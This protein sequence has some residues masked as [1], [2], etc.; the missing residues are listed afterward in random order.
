M[1]EWISTELRHPVH[2]ESVLAHWL[3]A[4][5]N[6]PMTVVAKY[7]FRKARLELNSHVYFNPEDS[8]D[9]YSIP[10]YWM[11]IPQVPVS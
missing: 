9:D 1:N 8:H 2:N 4:H 3:A 5:G 7:H 10:D 11:P 6:P